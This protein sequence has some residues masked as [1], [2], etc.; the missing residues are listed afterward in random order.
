MTMDGSARGSTRRGGR[1]AGAAALGLIVLLPSCKVE[2][3][4]SADSSSPDSATV[5]EPATGA[6]PAALPDS[7]RAGAAAIEPPQPDV[8]IPPADPA[9][10]PPDTTT[11]PAPDE[12]ATLRTALGIP[13]Q[14]IRADQLR[15]TF[16]EARG[17]R[18]HEALDIAA[19]RNTPVLSAADGKLTKLH[20]SVAG[21]LMIYAAD[22]TDR[23][24]LMYGHLER[25]ADGMAEG[26]TL[27]KGQVIGYVGTSGNAPP[28]APHLH[29]AIMRGQ[30]S[31]AWWRGT[32][33]NPYPLLTR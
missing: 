16:A 29:F 15:D 20:A 21:G 14:G 32:A 5:A 12:L 11:T 27:T 2:R 8:P 23:F 30:P 22:P 4:R 13:V 1:L 18:V 7:G 26:M 28:D 24:V 31:A 33:V 6:S 17:S 10:R 19:P 3:L 25:Y 9:S